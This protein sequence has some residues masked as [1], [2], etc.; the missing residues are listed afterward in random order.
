MTANREHPYNLNDRDLFALDLMGQNTEYLQASVHQ[1]KGK[2]GELQITCVR[3]KVIF[4]P[5]F[6]LFSNQK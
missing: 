6:S 1:V 4:T 5:P 3:T 2:I